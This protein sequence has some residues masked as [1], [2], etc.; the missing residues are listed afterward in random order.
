MRIINSRADLE[1]LQGTPNWLP[2]LRALRGTCTI[3]TDVAIYPAGY[4][5]PGYNG[6]TVE[7]QWQDVAHIAALD[8]FGLTQPQLDAMI[9]AEQP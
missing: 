1:A 9:A 3:R 6:E 8:R 7:P 2:A 5:M 4:G